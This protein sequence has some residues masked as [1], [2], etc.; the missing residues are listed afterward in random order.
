MVDSDVTRHLSVLRPVPFL[1]EERISYLR[2]YANRSARALNLEVMPMLD[3]VEVSNDYGSQEEP[4]TK[5]QVVAWNAERGSHW[6]ILRNFA[7]DPNILILNEMDWGMARSGNV[8]TT[9]LLAN[10][11]KMNYAYGVEFMELTNGNEGE[12][13]TTI[14]YAN[15]IGYHGNVVMSKWPITETKVVRLHELYDHLYKEKTSGMDRGERRLGGRMALF[16]VTSLDS[17]KNLLVVAA[18]GHGGA[19]RGKLKAD[20][21]LI[22]REIEAF[23]SRV[24]AIFLGGDL[25]GVL[26]EE[27][28]NTCGTLPLRDTNNYRG[29]RAIPTWRVTCKDGR[30]PFARF[31]RG[32]WLIARNGNHTPGSDMI[33]ILNNTVKTVHPYKRLP[34]GR[35][36]CVSDHSIIMFTA[37]L[38]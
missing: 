25:P 12:I 2:N 28:Q 37:L 31:E 15:I 11:T 7:P 26:V 30:K 16:A 8:H 5:I 19:P 27:L 33:Q 34:N 22:C 21:R 18:H 9:P 36:D 20:A 32:D 23:S 3:R 13:N 35:Y 38:K 4:K 17:E 1:L 14:G 29:R 6:H 24:E 10:S